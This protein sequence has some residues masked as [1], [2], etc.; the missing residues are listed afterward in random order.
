MSKSGAERAKATTARKNARAAALG[1]QHAWN[2][3]DTLE[4]IESLVA[5]LREELEELKKERF[6]TCSNCNCDDV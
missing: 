4:Y 3:F 5:E 6:L 2:S 1:S